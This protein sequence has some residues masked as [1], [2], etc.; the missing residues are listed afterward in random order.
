M[1]MGL[2][3][4]GAL[5]TNKAEAQTHRRHPYRPP[6]RGVRGCCGAGGLAIHDS[7]DEHRRGLEEADPGGVTVGGGSS[8]RADP[9]TSSPWNSPA[10]VGHPSPPT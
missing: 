3:V 1:T 4:V 9:T 10:T 5:Y 2:G 6:H 8:A 7:I